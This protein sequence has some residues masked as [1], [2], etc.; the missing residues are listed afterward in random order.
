[1][2]GRHPLIGGSAPFFS[3]RSMS[4]AAVGERL[5]CFGGV[6]AAGTESILDVTDACWS[7]D[8]RSMEWREVAKA[9]PWPEARRCPG[10]VTTTDGVWLWGGSGVAPAPAGTR[11]TFL[12]DWWLFQSATDSWT[13]VRG[14]DDHLVAPT[15]EHE[16]RYPSPRYT[17]VL[18]PVSQ[19][20][21]LFSGYTEDRLG[22]RKLNDAWLCG[23]GNWKKL[24]PAGPAGYHDGAAWPGLRYGSGSAALDGNAYVF[25]GFSDDGDHND[26]WEFNGRMGEWRLLRAE[27]AD[28]AQ[29]LPRYCAAVTA[30][31]G[32]VLVFGGRSRR[33]P[34]ANYNDLWSFDL[35]TRRWECL[36]PNRLPHRY[37]SAAEFPGY[38]AKSGSAVSGGYWYLWGGEGLRGHVSDFWRLSLSAARWE[39]IQEARPDDPEF[40]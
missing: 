26:I 9:G 18:T 16:D 37:D 28:P 14:S 5:V 21:L 29:P 8:T 7:F 17:P 39:L 15:S 1:V 32:R 34:K 6:G 4:M 33:D 23:R 13:L 10:F 35:T 36:S 27:S 25:G 2:T 12:N 3:R 22:H 11:H 30:D 38:H 31:S 40:W 20:M 24:E 19:S